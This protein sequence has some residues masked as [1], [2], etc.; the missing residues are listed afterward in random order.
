MTDFFLVDVDVVS[1][2]L[3]FDLVVLNPNSKVPAYVGWPENAKKLER[4]MIQNI[5]ESGNNIGIKTGDGLVVLDVDYK[6]GAKDILASIGISEDNFPQTPRVR[7]PS[8]GVHLYFSGQHKSRSI[9]G[10]DLQSTGKQVVAPPS[11]VESGK[12]TWE[13][14]PSECPMIP[15][16]N[17]ILALFDRADLKRAPKKNSGKVLPMFPEKKG[18][19][20]YPKPLI[21]NALDNIKTVSLPYNDWLRVGMALKNEGFDYKVWDQW[22][23]TLPDYTP[24]INYKKWEGFQYDPSLTGAL[25]TMLAKERGWRPSLLDDPDLALYEHISPCMEPQTGDNKEE[26]QAPRVDIIADEFKNL[27]RPNLNNAPKRTQWLIDCIAEYADD[28]QPRFARATAVAIANWLAFAVSTSPVRAYKFSPLS[29][30]GVLVGDSGTGKGIFSAIPSMLLNK[31]MPLIGLDEV[32]SSHALIRSLRDCNARIMAKNEIGTLFV[33]STEDMWKN[34]LLGAYCSAWSG[35]KISGK[36]TK[37]KNESI[38]GVDFPLL[39]IWGGCTTAQ[40]KDLLDNKNFNKGGLFYRVD[41]ILAQAVNK[42]KSKPDVDDKKFN[43][44]IMEIIDKKLKDVEAAYNEGKAKDPLDLTGQV[45][46]MPKKLVKIS[47]EAKDKLDELKIKYKNLAVDLE[48]QQEGVMAGIINR[49]YEKICRTS[50]AIAMFESDEYPAKIT[51]EIVVWA[52]QHHLDLIE[53]LKMFAKIANHDSNHAK[54]CESIMQALHRIC[55]DDTSKKIQ[56]KQLK[57]TNIGQI[58]G[59]KPMDMT[60]ALIDLM[61]M[62]KIL[63]EKEGRSKIITLL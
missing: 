10:F 35:E 18:L 41:F 28:Y 43:P 33:A 5:I 13:V 54:L 50:S 38:E 40:F 8:G 16:P 4:D 17:E 23:M 19:G 56:Y 3:R 37:D 6:N 44:H 1:E 46:I 26:I 20:A 15:I 58:R 32:Q 24:Q 25:I 52:N 47:K 63:I 39:C 9:Q 49:L 60:Q 34:D 12:Y 29:H 48:E 45:M 61:E 62:G 7:T 57:L 55:G 22:N 11:V 31:I 53:S 14:L 27:Y 59:A 30:F 42:E 51:E 2:L 21:L 36:V